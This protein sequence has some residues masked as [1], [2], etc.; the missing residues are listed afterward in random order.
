MKRVI[1]LVVLVLIPALAVGE[2]NY[3]IGSAA[4]ND[5]NYMESGTGD[6]N[7]GAATT[8]KTG[9]YNSLGAKYYTISLAFDIS[10]FE[11]DSG[12]TSSDVI[13]ADICLI[14]AVTPGILG[15]YD[16]TITFGLAAHDADS[17]FEGD[18]TGACP[19][20]NPGQ[21]DKR[22][23]C[24]DAGG[25]CGCDAPTNVVWT[26]GGW[27]TDDVSAAYTTDVVLNRTMVGG[28]TLKVTV[29]DSYKAALDAGYTKFWV[30]IYWREAMGVGEQQYATFRSADG[31]G[32]DSP[33]LGV[34]VSVA[35]PATNF[36]RRKMMGMGQ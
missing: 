9:N 17:S 14:F 19:S 33:Y 21:N 16:S 15:T 34:N 8:I 7:N 27:S 32:N 3:K 30:F 28:D 6:N 25:P 20:P 1:L 10:D 2:Y 36:R 26:S 23:L 22:I 24:A 35:T 12:W 31:Y 5:D 11:A 4:R 13:L 29:T 18:E